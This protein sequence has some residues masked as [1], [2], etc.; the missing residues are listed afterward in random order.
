[1]KVHTYE[2]LQQ[3]E[4]YHRMFGITLKAS[5]Y[6]IDG[7]LI[8]TGT[9]RKKKQLIPIFNAWDI[10]KVLLTHHHEDHSGLAYWLESEKKVPIYSHKLGVQKGTI[11][12]RLPFY[13]R[14]FWG[15]KKS[16]NPLETDETFSTKQ[17]TWEVIH[18]P[19]HA[20]DHIALYNKE[21]GWLFGGDLYVQRRPKS[22]FSFES[23]PHLIQSLEKVLTYDFTTYICSHVGV[24]PNGY[25]VIAEKLSYLYFIQKK[26]LTLHKQGLSAVDIRKQL[27]PEHHLLH[28]LSFFDNSPIH[29][30]R[31]IINEQ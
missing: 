24:I 16:Y 27:L 12:S 14:V 25:E 31:S 7:L 20:K 6:F 9:I 17:Y 5:I 28:Y 21:K 2:D 1:M 13:R 18:T 22:M 3:I 15:P 19:G 26:V 30:I 4:L 23:V 29:L 10:D 11:N 8:D